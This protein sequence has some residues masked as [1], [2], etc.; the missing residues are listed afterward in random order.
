MPG[1]GGGMWG[2]GILGMFGFWALLIWG[3][4][5][6][7]RAWNGGGHGAEATLARRFAVGDIDEDEYERR[8]DVL[9]GER[10]SAGWALR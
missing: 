10:S 2:F 3:G 8:L 5:R 4:V 7:S 9:R 6:L 1:L